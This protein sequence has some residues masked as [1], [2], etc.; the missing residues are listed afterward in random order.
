MEN[1]NRSVHLLIC[2]TPEHWWV[3]HAPVKTIPPQKEKNP[4]FLLIFFF[5]WENYFL[6]FFEIWGIICAKSSVL[7]TSQNLRKSPKTIFFLLKIFLVSLRTFHHTL[8]QIYNFVYTFVLECLLNTD[9]INST[10]FPPFLSSNRL[11]ITD[12]MA[13][14]VS[15]LFFESY[16]LIPRHL[17]YCQKQLRSTVYVVIVRAH[18][19]R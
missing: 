7:L 3:F 12:A 15:S 19:S 13:S 11:N 1:Y 6:K 10:S 18:L 4:N 14:L 2:Q 8:M 5:F 9:N 17:F 16:I